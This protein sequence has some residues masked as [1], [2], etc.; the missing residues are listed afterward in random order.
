MFCKLISYCLNGIDTVKVDVE[1]D[2]SDGLPYFDIV[3]LA[4]SS[5]KESKERVRSA[6]RNSG[7]EF[8]IKRI[9]INLAP[10]DMRKEGCIYDLPIALGIL[11][12]IGIIREEKLKNTL[13]IGELALDGSLRQ[14]RGILPILC[15]TKQDKIENCVIPYSNYEEAYALDTSGIIGANSLYEIVSYLND[16]KPLRP[17]LQTGTSSK[18]ENTLDFKDVKGQENAK[19]GLMICAAGFHHALLIGPPRFR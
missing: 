12:C 11:C 8:P 15:A 16:D 9:T 13:F 17:F 2:L 7:F 10:A 5:V 4:N 3:G 18:H 1:I 19:K 14:V 6:I